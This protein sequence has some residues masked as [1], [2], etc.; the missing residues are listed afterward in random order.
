MPSPVQCAAL[1]LHTTYELPWN[2][3]AV[4]QCTIAQSIRGVKVPQN[5][6]KQA[7]YRS[8][9]CPPS[10][11]HTHTH[12]HMS[13]P[14][15]LQAPSQR[16]SVAS[17]GGGGGPMHSAM[18]AAATLPHKLADSTPP[19]SWHLQ[20]PAQ[21]PSLLMVPAGP[22]TAP[23]PAHGTCRVRCSCVSSMCVGGR[24]QGGEFSYGGM[25]MGGWVSCMLWQLGGM[26]SLMVWGGMV[27]G[28]V[29]RCWVV[30]KALSYQLYRKAP[31]KALPQPVTSTTCMSSTAGT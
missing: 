24:D 26:G 13:H 23:H 28:E 29:R 10:H 18:K 15:P 3:R 1:D 19:C 5:K 16:T 20:G 4:L 21:H 17:S 9:G 7:S 22:S 27:R 2:C 31:Q 25:G 30:P 12:T 8:P 14:Q 6:S 11:A